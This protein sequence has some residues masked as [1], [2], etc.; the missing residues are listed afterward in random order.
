MSN[1]TEKND[2]AKVAEAPL[3]MGPHGRAV[4][5]FDPVRQAVFLQALGKEPIVGRACRRA[6]ITTATAYRMKERSPAF[7]AAWNEA[8][9]ASVDDLESHGWERARESD[10]VMLRM[11]EAH[12]PEKYSRKLDVKAQVAVDFVVDLVP[13]EQDAVEGELLED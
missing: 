4:Q 2:L 12:R 1:T 3:A 9:T 11:L 13:M 8:L 10:S 7:A 5:L 6:G